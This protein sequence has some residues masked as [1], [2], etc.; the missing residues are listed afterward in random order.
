MDFKR[1]SC[2]AVVLTVVC[3]CV[4]STLAAPFLFNAGP[5]S[6]TRFG[7]TNGEHT[8]EAFGS[9]GSPNVDT[10][11]FHFV[12]GFPA[13][14]LNMS[15]GPGNNAASA[16]IQVEVNT[17][18]ASG[19]AQPGFSTVTIRERGTYASTNPIPS[20]DFS[21]WGTAWMPLVFAPN[22]GGFLTPVAL[23]APTF[24]PTG[25]DVGTWMIEV[26]WQIGDPALDASFIPGGYSH[27]DIN[28]PLF[29]W[30]R[31]RVKIENDLFLTAQG[32]ANG[33]SLTKTR[34]DIFVPEPSSVLLCMLAAGP[35]AIRRSRR[36]GV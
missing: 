26:V 28:N 21:G 27:P 14:P 9:M 31:F 35:L 19:G 25:P 18:N 16:E 4:S 32:V 12:N 3:I 20:N 1:I 30:E 8:N 5:D 17:Q 15:V 22:G 13:H 34:M 24:T 36:R 7:W 10:L 2:V 11:G 23:P 29:P 33:S 6:N